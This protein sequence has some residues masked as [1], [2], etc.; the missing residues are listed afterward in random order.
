[1][2]KIWNEAFWKAA[3]EGAAGSWRENRAARL[4]M[5]PPIAALGAITLT[6]GL[7]AEPFVDFSLRAAHQL[8]E[9][10]AYIEAVLGR[11]GLPIASV[12]AA[13]LP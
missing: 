8:L 9:P 6:I 13:E 2:V 4:A 5:L 3:P 10:T 7:A 12:P 11:A 1:M